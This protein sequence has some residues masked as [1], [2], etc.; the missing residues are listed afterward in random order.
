MLDSAWLLPEWRYTR[1]LVETMGQEMSM[2]PVEYDQWWENVQKTQLGKDHPLAA[3]MLTGLHG[4]R[5]QW[6][7]YALEHAMIGVGL[8][9]MK[10]RA[11][12]NILRTSDASTGWEY[13]FSH[14]KKTGG[15][16]L[17]SKLKVAGQP[18]V[19]SFTRP[20]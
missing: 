8:S 14:V 10:D 7:E 5:K 17:R 15:F 4:V 12:Y 18:L 9:L 19:L 6:S 11:A 13:S 1:S 2:D 3:V 16:E 20:R